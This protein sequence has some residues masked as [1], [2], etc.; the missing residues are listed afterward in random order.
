MKLTIIAATG[1]VGQQL[2]RQALAAGH[3]V[4]SVVRDPGKV[5]PSLRATRIV[6]AEL[7]GPDPAVLESAIA[8]ADA[9]VSGLGPASTAD[10]GIAVRGTRAIVAAMAATGVRRLVVV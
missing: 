1:G 5:P 9:V 6:T 10:A 7:A 2:L 3:D 4:T 8:G